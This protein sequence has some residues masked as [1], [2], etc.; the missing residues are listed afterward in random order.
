M[1]PKLES[2]DIEYLVDVLNEDHKGKREFSSVYRPD[3]WD[4]YCLNVSASQAYGFDTAPIERENS[5]MLIASLLFLK[6][7]NQ[8]GFW[9]AEAYHRNTWSLI[10]AKLNQRSK[11]VNLDEPQVM[12][13]DDCFYWESQID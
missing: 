3:F 11:E 8:K 9:H 7:Q 12:A 6:P 10:A 13:R 5:K 4:I 1:N 2:S